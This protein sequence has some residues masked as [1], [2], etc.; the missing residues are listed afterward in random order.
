MHRHQRG[1]PE[2]LSYS[3]GIVIII[4]CSVAFKVHRELRRHSEVLDDL[5]SIPQPK[6]QDLY[7]GWPWGELGFGRW[8][9]FPAVTAVLH[10]ST[11]YLVKRLRQRSM[12]RRLP[13]LPGTSATKPP[14]TPLGTTTCPYPLLVIDLALTLSPDLA[15]L[16]PAELYARLP[17]SPRPAP[18]ALRRP[19][20]CT[21]SLEPL[22]RAYAP[23]FAARSASSSASAKPLT[24]ADLRS[25]SLL[26]RSIM[27]NL[28]CHAD[29]P[30]S[31]LSDLEQQNLVLCECLQALLALDGE[32]VDTPLPLSTP[33]PPPPLRFITTTR[34][35]ST[36]RGSTGNN[37]KAL[38]MP[39]L[40]TLLL[41][42]QEGKD[43]TGTGTKTFVRQAL[44]L[45]MASYSPLL[46]YT[47]PICDRVG[48]GRPS[49][50]LRYRA[51]SQPR[52]PATLACSQYRSRA[53]CALTRSIHASS[54]WLAVPRD[55]SDARPALSHFRISSRP[56]SKVRPVRI[57]IMCFMDLRT[58]FMDY[59]PNTKCLSNMHNLYCIVITLD[60]KL[61]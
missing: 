9:H 60:F 22:R 10:R 35:R 13:S 41:R 26:A 20:M 59:G 1:S 14:P 27:H 7:D 31:W 53:S 39:A 17:C 19:R 48:V 49:T 44:K 5:F 28:S 45:R 40:V 34:A 43:R 30:S 57:L 36:S 38:E 23:K 52:S 46:G 18:E 6:D 3:S 16:P 50:S 42:R 58:D 47:L 33:A 32:G 55:V 4:A 51:A 56:A 54:R 11:K 21:S 25:T 15:H 29:S 61:L 2:T 12:T 24:A 37:G 8:S